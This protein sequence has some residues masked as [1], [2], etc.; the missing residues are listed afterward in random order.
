MRPRPF[1][2]FDPLVRSAIARATAS[3]NPS[4]ALA[5]PTWTVN[6][7][8]GNDRNAGTPSAPLRTLAA[9]ADRMR[10]TVPTNLPGAV[11]IAA[12]TDLPES[13]PWPFADVQSLLAP[14]GFVGSLFAQTTPP[15]AIGTFT[16]RNNAAGTPNTITAEGQTGAFW[17]PYVGM[18]LHDTTHDAWMHVV[19][20]LGSATAE[21]SEP[22]G[23]GSGIDPPSLVTI[24]AGDALVV[25][26]QSSLYA[27]SIRGCFSVQTAT[28]AGF[29]GIE[30]TGSSFPS[31]DRCRFSDDDGYEANPKALPTIVFSNCHMGGAFSAGAG[32]FY[33]GCVLGLFNFIAVHREQLLFDGFVLL[34][35]RAH[36]SGV[37]CT[38]G[39]AGFF[40][41]GWFEG[42]TQPAGVVELDAQH[43]GPPVMFGSA[44]FDVTDGT[45]MIVGGATA[46]ESML[47]TG[48]YQ[49]DGQA[50]ATSV[51]AAGVAT[52]GIAVTPANLDAHGNLQSPATGSRMWIRI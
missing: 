14:I 29:C 12:Q 9:V 31:F 33:G 35:T 17:T 50:T 21:I 39:C 43:Y 48:G 41:G 26:R 10:T 40:G 6:A 23:P 36:L 19:A 32:V 42:D 7:T 28:L 44:T 15:L 47:L 4:P 45:Q 1:G 5:Q 46:A 18:L 37:G 13:D 20:D 38:I 22:M 30:A 3:G 24:A 2:R 25:Y 16:P 49:I 8:S 34:K 51:S 11:T 52:P 27:P